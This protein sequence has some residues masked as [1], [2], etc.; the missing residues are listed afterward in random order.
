M[1]EICIRRCNRRG[2]LGHCKSL[3]VCNNGV[4]IELGVPAGVGAAGKDKGSG[5]EFVDCVGLCGVGVVGGGCGVC[6]WGLHCDVQCLPY[7]RATGGRCEAGAECGGSD[8]GG[9]RLIRLVGKPSELK[10]NYFKDKA[11][12]IG[13]APL[14][15]LAVW[16]AADDEFGA[17][18]A[19]DPY[20]VV[21]PSPGLIL[22]AGGAADLAGEADATAC[23][24][25][26][27]IATA[28]VGGTGNDLASS[29]LTG[30]SRIPIASAAASSSDDELGATAAVDPYAVVVPSPGLILD[31]GGTADLAGEADATACIGVAEVAS[32][33]VGGAGDGLALIIS[34]PVAAAT[35]DDEFSSAA[36]V[37]PH[38]AVVPSPGLVLDAGGAA[39][40][41]RETDAATSV[42][43]TEVASA[44]V[45]GAGDGLALTLAVAA[46]EREEQKKL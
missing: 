24:D 6:L 45:G 5:C 1:W 46:K 12:R 21:V 14:V 16:L 17:T 7:P 34:S 39:D 2:R 38:A 10:A 31:A 20:A 42:G 3:P 22:D 40:L 19:V 23:I 33:V 26:A 8:A 15:V 32:A 18:A 41:A 44:V 25:V 4:R 36:A 27:E 37:D 28:V 9:G 30:A 11:Q 35:A 43:A 13:S 29:P